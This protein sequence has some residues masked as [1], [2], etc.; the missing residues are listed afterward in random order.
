MRDNYAIV[1]NN[2]DA[3]TPE[4]LEGFFPSGL[5]GNILH[6]ENHKGVA[7]RDCVAECGR[8]DGSGATPP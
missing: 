6:Q 3:L 1:F 7:G 8:S 2:A 5:G 4:E